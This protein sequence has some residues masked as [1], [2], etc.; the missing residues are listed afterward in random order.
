[1]VNYIKYE[2]RQTQ[3]III[4]WCHFGCHWNLFVSKSKWQCDKWMFGDENIIFGDHWV[5]VISDKIWSGKSIYFEVLFLLFFNFF[6]KNHQM[7]FPDLGGTEP[8]VDCYWPKPTHVPS[9]ASA[10]GGHDIS[11]EEPAA[12]NG[13]DPTGPRQ[14]VSL[15]HYTSSYQHLNFITFEK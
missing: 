1:M 6:K 2:H 4:I 3:K 13:I 15:S 10:P 12:L 8:S 9:L 7:T 11:F 14:T 5:W